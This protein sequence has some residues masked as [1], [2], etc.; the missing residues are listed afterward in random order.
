MI[1]KVRFHICFYMMPSGRTLIAHHLP[2]GLKELLEAH[3][4]GKF[5]INP[6]KG[7]TR[8]TLKIQQDDD[9][10]EE[11][12]AVT[13]NETN[14]IQKGDNDPQQSSN[15]SGVVNVRFVLF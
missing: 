11:Q 2:L 3:Y 9:E 10:E 7:R 4:P 14:A 12:S 15:P 8:G 6:A 13:G 5:D 1:F